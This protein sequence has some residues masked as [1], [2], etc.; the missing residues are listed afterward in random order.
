MSSGFSLFNLPLAYS[1]NAWPTWDFSSVCNALPKA[2]TKKKAKKV[3]AAKPVE[4]AKVEE[5][6]AEESVEEEKVEEEIDFSL[7]KKFLEQYKACEVKTETKPAKCTP[8]DCSWQSCCA[9][10]Y[11]YCAPSWGPGVYTGCNTNFAA[12][13]WPNNACDKCKL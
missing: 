1:L 9:P 8:P 12:L 11:N 7:L 3:K 2:E 4:E 13:L 6:K 5:P 10:N